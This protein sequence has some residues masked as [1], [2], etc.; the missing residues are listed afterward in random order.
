M[1]RY[2][3]ISPHTADAAVKIVLVYLLVGSCATLF[4]KSK[5]IV[6][7]GIQAKCGITGL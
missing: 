6:V 4:Y 2:R 1:T 3:H 7:A 5:G